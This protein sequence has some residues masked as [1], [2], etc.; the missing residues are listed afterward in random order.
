M[1]RMTIVS[2]RIRLILTYIMMLSNPKGYIYNN[3]FKCLLLCFYLRRASISL[4]FKVIEG[5][6]VREWL[7]LY[8]GCNRKYPNFYRHCRSKK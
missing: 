3:Y 2:V 1:L 5:N 6:T 4:S 8:E 7:L